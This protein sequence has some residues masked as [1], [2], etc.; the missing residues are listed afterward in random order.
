VARLA[1]ARAAILDPKRVKSTKAKR[2]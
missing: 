2:K 1:A